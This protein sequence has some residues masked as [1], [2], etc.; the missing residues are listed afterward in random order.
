LRGAT[1]VFAAELRTDESVHKWVLA[2][3]AILMN[4][5]A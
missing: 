4:V 1:Y 2:G 3:V 5:E